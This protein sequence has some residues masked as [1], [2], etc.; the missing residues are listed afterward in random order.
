M[1]RKDSVVPRAI[2]SYIMIAGLEPGEFAIRQNP[3]ADHLSI[4]RYSFAYDLACSN[5]YLL[6]Q[7]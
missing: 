3:L 7:R 2:T 1:K 5:L 6:Y 4:M